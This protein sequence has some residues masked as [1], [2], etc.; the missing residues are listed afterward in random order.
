MLMVYNMTIVIGVV[1]FASMEMVKLFRIVDKK[2]G[3][4]L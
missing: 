3:C 2:Y 1:V 4:N